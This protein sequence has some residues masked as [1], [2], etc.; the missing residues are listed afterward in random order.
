M[1]KVHSPI[2]KLSPNIVSSI[3][4][5]RNQGTKLFLPVLQMYSI[6][7]WGNSALGIKKMLKIGFLKGMLIKLLLQY[8]YPKFHIGF[9]TIKTYRTLSLYLLNITRAE[10]GFYSPFQ[11]TPVAYVK[12]DFVSI[13]LHNDCPCRL[14]KWRTLFAMFVPASLRIRLGSNY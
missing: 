2:C 9:I 6:P 13:L 10:K 4:T 11:A 14:V 3:T 7:C 1:K 5:T 12:G 8:R